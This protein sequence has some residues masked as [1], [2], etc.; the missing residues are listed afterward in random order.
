[1]KP[2]VV[3]GKSQSI[4][5]WSNPMLV[6]VI[7]FVRQWPIDWHKLDY[8]PEYDDNFVFRCFITESV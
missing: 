1:M 3:V 2:H 7:F 6:L 5:R 8:E 4:E